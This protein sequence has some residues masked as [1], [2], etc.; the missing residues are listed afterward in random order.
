MSKPTDS[1][2]I[3]SHTFPKSSSQL[4]L[5]RFDIGAGANEKVT[6]IKMVE[7]MFDDVLWLV[8]FTGVFPEHKYK[9]VK[10][11]QAKKHI[12][13]MTGDGVNDAPALKKADIG[14][15]VADATDAAR[16]AADIVLTQ[17]GK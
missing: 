6:S 4:T 7:P 14:I 3:L 12:V 17:P 9:I 5:D 16:N 8:F 15:A 1:Q 11:L 13:G 2:V 10:M